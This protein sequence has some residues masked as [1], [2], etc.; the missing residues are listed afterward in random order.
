MI[1]IDTDEIEWSQWRRVESK[2]KHS[3]VKAGRQ[4]VK[5]ERAAGQRRF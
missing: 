2:I 4:K 1:L 3:K 5:H